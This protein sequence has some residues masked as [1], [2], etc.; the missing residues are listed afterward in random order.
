MARKVRAGDAKLLSRTAR[1]TLKPSRKPYYRLI[2]RGIHLG[3]RKPRRGPG[4]WVVR[5]Y[6]GGDR[7]TVRNI[8]TNDGHPIFAD[9]HEDANGGTVLDFWQAQDAARAHKNQL[10]G[11]AGPYTLA[12][13]M[14][15]YFEFLENEGR[16]AHTIR[17]ARYRAKAFILPKIGDIELPALTAD[18]LRRWRNDLVRT[19]PRLRT[20]KGE[21]QKHREVASDD[22]RRARRS[23]ANRTWTILR[24]AL[25]H[26]FENGKAASDLAWRKVKPFKNVDAARPRYLSIAEAKRLINASEPDFRLLVQAALQTGARYSE[27]ARLTVSDF[28]PDVGTVQIQQSKSGKPRHIVL[29]DEGAAFFKQLSA[30]RAGDETMLRKADGS[31]WEM[32]HQLRPMADAVTRAKIKPTISFHGLRHTWASHAMMNGMPLMVVAR[33]LGHVDTRMVE[34]HYGH[35]APSYVA[36]AVRA[37]APKFGFKPD[38]KIATLT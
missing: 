8:T 34:K 24:A 23:S 5:R 22:A 3:Y 6:I 9:D 38:K 33:N 11:N 32:S 16:G 27:L 31:T 18:K 12:T 26:A 13:A 15:D 35:L 21:A 36:E 19:A 4:A 7:Y 1:E 17:D 14:R 37:G 20:R 25:N 29:T 10:A 30:G 28:N 2:E